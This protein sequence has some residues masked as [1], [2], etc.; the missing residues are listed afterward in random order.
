MSYSSI[1]VLKLK[2]LNGTLFDKPDTVNTVT[3]S[4]QSATWKVETR[5]VLLKTK[6][7]KCLNIKTVI[8]TS[9]VTL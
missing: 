2:C 4:S 7:I 5:Q 9:G 3:V 8:L 6:I 1:V